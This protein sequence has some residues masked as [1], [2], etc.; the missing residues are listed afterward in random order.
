[1]AI[2]F[3]L[4]L[5]AVVSW[6]ATR[7]GDPP[8]ELDADVWVADDVQ[9]ATNLKLKTEAWRTGRTYFSPEAVAKIEADCA[10]AQARPFVPSDFQLAPHEPQRRLVPS[11][12]HTPSDVGIEP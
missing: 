11:S 4:A 8:T 2:I 3:L 1:M 6:L 5:A 9:R 7:N 10:A 12:R